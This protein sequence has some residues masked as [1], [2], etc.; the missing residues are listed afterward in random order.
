MLKSMDFLLL[1]YNITV[2]MLLLYWVTFWFSNY[3]KKHYYTS[4]L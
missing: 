4:A 3:R 1:E 2:C